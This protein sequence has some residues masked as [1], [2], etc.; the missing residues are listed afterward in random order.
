MVVDEL[1]QRHGFSVKKKVFN[2]VTGRGVL[3]GVEVLLV[4]PQTYMN[5]SGYSVGPLFEYFKCDYDDLI[6]VHDD[7]DLP[8]GK[9]RI[10]RGAGHGGHNGVRSIIEELGGQNFYR[11][12]I[13]VSRP[14]LSTEAADHVLQT[15]SKEERDAVVVIVHRA[16]DAVRD[17]LTCS[18]RD[19]QQRYHTDPFVPE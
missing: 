11:V 6:V 12:R 2:A 7:I 16:A 14:P 3:D 10:A 19:V 9:L 13:G 17:M 18:L 5:R 8:L 15:F 4:K 1:A